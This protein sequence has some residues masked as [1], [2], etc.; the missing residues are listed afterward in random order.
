MLPLLEKFNIKKM[1]EKGL[2]LSAKDIYDINNSSLKDAIVHFGGGCTAEIVSDQGLLFTN[3]HCGYG[4][5]QKLS[6]V[7]HDYLN[8]G[9][10]AMNLG[11]ELPAEGLT[12]TFIDKFTDVTAQIEKAVSKAKN[13][14]QYN[15]LFKTECDK[16]EKA[17][18]AKDPTDRKSVV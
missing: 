5:I 3:H 1:H 11:Q 18:I 16:I 13:K 2:K 7:E 6:T 10:W 14:E 15:K 8:N 12:V 4:A 9:Y 17:A